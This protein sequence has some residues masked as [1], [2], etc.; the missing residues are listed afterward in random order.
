MRTDRSNASE[1]AGLRFQVLSDD[2]IAEIHARSLEVLDR[3]GVFIESDEVLQML[4]EAGCRVRNGVAKFPP[5]LVEWAIGAAPSHFLLHD[6]S[7]ENA[8]NVGG[9]NTYFGLG[10][11]LLYMLD[12]QTGERRKFVKSDTEK[13][14]RVAD[15]LPNIDWVMGL[16]TISDCDPQYSEIH[17]FEAM[18]R[19]TTKPLIIWSESLQGVQ[20][21]IKMAEAVVGGEEQLKEAPFIASYSE[22][23]SPLTQNKIA[24]EKLLITADYG[25]PTVHTP[26]PQAGASAPVTLAG[27][28][29]SINAENLASVTISQVRRPG[30]PIVIGGVIGTMDMLQAQLAYGAPEMQLMLA[31]Y[32][33]IAH[34]YDLPTWGTAG[35][36][37]SKLVDQQAAIEAAQSVLYSALSGSNLVHDTGYMASGTQGALEM[38][39]MVDELVSMAKYIVRGIRVNEGT[40]ALDAIDHVG[41]G[42][43]FLTSDHTFKNFRDQLWFPTLMDRQP[44]DKWEAA[45]SKTMG[46]RI[47]EKVQRI[48]DTHEPEPLP[49][50]VVKEVQGFLPAAETVEGESLMG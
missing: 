14:A 33:D 50:D 18:V 30:A 28:L 20:D 21:I 45:G 5:G 25:I 24:V 6:R 41:P 49:E 11:T 9:Y 47:K 34:F 4:S 22:P 23:I 44:H 12:P 17:E 15:A 35:C 7:G 40:L 32:M 37:D 13:A 48:L 27:E 42:G 3:T 39:V 31:A 16:G 36:T 29:V 43:E 46:D 19:N 10:P 8:L 1:R 38:L 26:I 2:E